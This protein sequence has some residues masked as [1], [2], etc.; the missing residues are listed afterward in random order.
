MKNWM[1]PIAPLLLPPRRKRN[2]F[3][4][5][6]QDQDDTPA[7][8]RLSLMVMVLGAFAVFF[9]MPNTTG[10]GPS[11]EIGARTFRVIRVIDGDTF[12]IEYDGEPTSVRLLGYDAPEPNEPGGAEATAR[13][14][15]LIDGKIVRLEFAEPARPG[16]AYKRDHFGRLL[17]RVNVDGVAVTGAL[18]ADPPP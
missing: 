14:R 9:F 18:G 7:M 1:T 16:A 17:A 10:C 12:V 4:S 3:E 6:L 15:E 11:R 2:D 8:L 13:L 5:W